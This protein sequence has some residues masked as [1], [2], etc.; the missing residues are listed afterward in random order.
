MCLGSN[1]PVVQRE[2]CQDAFRVPGWIEV[3][4]AARQMSIDSSKIRMEDDRIV[5][6][7]EIEMGKVVY[8]KTILK[9]PVT[10]E[11]ISYKAGHNWAYVKDENQITEVSWKDSVENETG[12]LILI[13]KEN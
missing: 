9:Y 12:K 1:C 11:L 10:V 13:S 2:E 3:L 6:S 8:L 4:E 5:I 7:G